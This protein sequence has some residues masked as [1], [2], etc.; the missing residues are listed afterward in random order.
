MPETTISIRPIRADEGEAL[1]S[2]RLQALVDSPSSFGSTLAETEAR[3]MDYWDYRAAIGEAG[4]E[5]VIF[6]ADDA[7]T[8][9]G[10]AGGWYEELDDGPAAELISMWVNPAYRARGIGRRLVERVID[11]ARERGARR[12]SL[13]VTQGNDSAASLY[14]RC[15]F[16]LTGE[17]QPHPSHPSLREERMVLDL[18]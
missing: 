6:V 9:V 7:G 3:P 11:W 5:S 17:T 1:R 18:E 10:L 13:R 15:G 12:I 16:V 8:W 4:E 2:I 14:V